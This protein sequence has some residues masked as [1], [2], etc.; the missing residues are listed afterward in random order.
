MEYFTSDLHLG[1]ENIIKLCNRPFS[2][3]EEMDNFLI[4]S[5]NRKVKKG[6]TVYILGDLIWENADAEKYLKKLNGKKIL[7]TGNHD[8][9][10]LNKGDYKSYFELIT[11]YLEINSNGHLITLCHYPMLEWKNS[12][13]EGSSKL[14]YLV[15]GH[16]H[17]NVR[18][19]YNPL[20]QMENALNAG[21]DINDFCPVTFQNL[22][23]NNRIFNWKATYLLKGGN[24]DEN[25]VARFK[26]KMDHEIED[27][28]LF[29]KILWFAVKNGSITI[30]KICRNFQTG[31]ARAGFYLDIMAAKGFISGSYGTDE[32]KVLIT[33]KDFIEKFGNLE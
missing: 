16:V 11:P 5:F 31:H 14:G 17:S 7:I 21:V 19:L 8:S 26:E 9:K 25:E 29:L 6:D 10:W 27:D 4:E 3:V 24:N 20:Y 2:S 22:I 13:K 33:E 1:H 32:R 30:S 28:E 23:E 12:R 15:Y 18:E